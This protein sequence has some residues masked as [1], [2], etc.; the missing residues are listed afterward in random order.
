MCSCRAGPGRARRCNA[1]M[2]SLRTTACCPTHRS[3]QRGVRVYV[4]LL[5]PA[6]PQQHRLFIQRRWPRASC[7]RAAAS[8]A[9]RPCGRPT[10]AAGAAAPDATRP[11]AV[12]PAPP[13]VATRATAARARPAHPRPRCGTVASHT[14]ARI[15]PLHHHGRGI[16]AACTCEDHRFHRHHRFGKCLQ[17]PHG[18]RQVV[19]LRT[20]GLHGRQ[21]LRQLRPGCAH[22]FKHAP[23]WM[24]RALVRP[25]V[26]FLLPPGQLGV[27]RQRVAGDVHDVLPFLQ[28]CEPGRGQATL[29]FGNEGLGHRPFRPAAAP[30]VEKLS[31]ALDWLMAGPEKR[32]KISGLRPGGRLPQLRRLFHQHVGLPAQRVVIA[33]PVAP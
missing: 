16:A 31:R 8:V 21:G 19:R 22:R 12:W 3:R 4:A 28:Q 33:Q 27:G 5:R 26:Q 6:W 20:C 11:D 14:L 9:H 7:A 25:V 30:L 18:L 24:T 15:Q 32:K 2:P 10:R 29:R 13:C 23:Q 1:T 17:P